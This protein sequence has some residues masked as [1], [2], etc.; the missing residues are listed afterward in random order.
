MNVW[1]YDFRERENNEAW[2]ASRCCGSV[3]W[4]VFWSRHFPLHSDEKLYSQVLKTVCFVIG[5]C[6]YECDRY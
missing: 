6:I 1:L 4:A 5:S 2:P 3:G